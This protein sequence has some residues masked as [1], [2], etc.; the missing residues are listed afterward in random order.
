MA[1][2]TPGVAAA[3]ELL[4][5]P[6]SPWLGEWSRFAAKVRF[7]D[8]P[9]D[10]VARTR[11]ALLDCIGAIASG[12]Q[13]PEC[14]AL[15]ARMIAREGGGDSP[16]IGFAGGARPGTAAFLNGTAGTMLELDEGNQYARG[17]PAIHVVPALLAAPRGDGAALLMAL[18]L[19][20]EMG[21]RVGIASK[22]NVAMHPHGTWGT[23][24]AATGIAKLHGATAE[25][26][27]GVINMA[28]TLGL[29]TSRKTMLEG[30]TVRN[31]YAGV[32]NMLG[33]TVWDLVRAG[34]EGERDGVA[35]I[36]GQVAANDFRP[37]EMVADLGTRWE[38]ARNY[39]K[40]HAACRYTHG[41]LD[42]LAK[43][44]AEHGALTPDQVKA[45]HVHTYVWA[46]QLDSPAAPNMLAAKFS[47]PFAI[48]T[49]IRH[50]AAT[51]PAFRGPA[52]EDPVT[53]AL[54]SRVTVDEDAAMT[55]MLPG[56]RPAR[57]AITLND[58]RVLSAEVTTN[59]GDTEDPFSEAE[60]REK[61]HDLAD[62]VYGRDR[63]TAIEEAVL[64]IG[65]HDEAT[66]L[67]ELLAR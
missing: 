55:A 31:T 22:L 6:P 44:V 59:R 7:A 28:S 9:A 23:L 45:V 67:V 11:L 1:M 53:L 41:A 64:A 4:A 2:L 57:V 15:A 36:F 39:F 20:Y 38:V 63:A 50:G 27:R 54:A 48:A 16:V 24:G 66:S 35:T 51:V 43:I 40:R 12:A 58:G 19:G 32:A 13:E 14:Q 52:R 60:V 29:A 26:F 56:L 18:A 61:F 34:F 42:A 21:S 8:L 17:H 37:D 5:T 30:G 47:I 62:P 65:P 46:A 49:F 3:T 33:I 10:V 25:E